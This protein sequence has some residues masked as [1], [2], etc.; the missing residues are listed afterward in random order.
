MVLRTVVAAA[1]ANA[2]GRA[3]TATIPAEVRLR[4]VDH[5]R[6]LTQPPD[7]PELFCP[8]RARGGRRAI[9]A[10]Q[11]R[12]AAWYA[13]LGAGELP[14]PTAPFPIFDREALEHLL[15]VRPAV[16]SFHFGLPKAADVAAIKARVS[17]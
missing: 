7:Q 11:A 8:R 12:L 15:A 5:L 14:A 4:Q 17:S 10:L 9:R 16:A 13:E 1:V 6:V 2:G 3:G